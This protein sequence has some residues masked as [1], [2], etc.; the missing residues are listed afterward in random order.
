MACYHGKVTFSHPKTLQIWTLQKRC[1]VIIDVFLGCHSFYSSRVLKMRHRVKFNYIIFSIIIVFICSFPPVL[2]VWATSICLGVTSSSVFRG[3]YRQ[4]SGDHVVLGM[5]LGD[6]MQTTCSSLLSSLSFLT[7]P[8][9]NVNFL[10]Y[11]NMMFL[12]FPLWF[13]W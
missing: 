4:C 10:K 11:K 1:A 13:W 6:C 8:F 3:H 2:I 9:L 5:K 7:F 12:Y